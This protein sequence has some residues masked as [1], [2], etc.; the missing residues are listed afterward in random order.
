M[1]GTKKRKEDLRN[2]DD[3]KNEEGQKYADD[4]KSLPS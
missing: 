2:E 4:L 1:E 3:K